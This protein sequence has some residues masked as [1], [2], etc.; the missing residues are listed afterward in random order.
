M[1]SGL[2]LRTGLLVGLGRLFRMA[3]QKVGQHPKPTRRTAFLAERELVHLGQ[4]LFSVLAVPLAQ[5]A[6]QPLWPTARIAGLALFPAASE[7]S[8]KRLLEMA[9]LVPLLF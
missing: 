2:A 6:S 7:D 3:V 9:L 5:Q 4:Q 8:Q 1:T